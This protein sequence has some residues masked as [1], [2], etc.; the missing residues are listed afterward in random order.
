[1]FIKSFIGII[2]CPDE[3][4]LKRTEVTLANLLQP[5][6]FVTHVKH[7]EIKLVNNTDR[8]QAG[9]IYKRRQSQ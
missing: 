2:H 4:P 8:W 7:N 9:T 1:M 6:E 3:N 5:T